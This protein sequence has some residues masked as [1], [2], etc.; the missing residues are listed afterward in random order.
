MLF[1]D[2]YGTQRG[3]LYVRLKGHWTSVAIQGASELGPEVLPL[4]G[5]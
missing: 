3:T 2:E 1:T 5:R 4:G